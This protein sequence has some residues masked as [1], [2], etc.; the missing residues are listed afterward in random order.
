[1]RRVQACA[2]PRNL[3]RYRPGKASSP[4]S[5]KI[6]RVCPSPSGTLKWRSET[7]R[8][9]PVRSASVKITVLFGSTSSNRVDQAVSDRL[10]ARHKAQWMVELTEAAN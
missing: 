5:P 6:T 8:D 3:E 7:A 2:S 10:K 4:A 1:M 9:I